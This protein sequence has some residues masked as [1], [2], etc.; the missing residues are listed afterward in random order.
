[1]ALLPLAPN[2]SPAQ[3]RWAACAIA[4][5]AL[6]AFHNALSGEFVLDDQASIV[7]NRTIRALWPFS[8]LLMPPAEAGVGGRPLANLTY[9]V[10][11]AISGQAVWSYRALNVMLHMAAALLLFG[12]VRRTVAFPVLRK[13]FGAHTLPIGALAAAVWAAHPLT[14]A[15]VDYV[16]QRT[17]QLMAL[18]YLAALYAFIRAANTG[19]RR[20]KVLCVAS[21]AAGMASKEV[22]VTA[23]VMIALYDRTFVA[24][25]FR[26]AWCARRRLYAALAGTWLLLAYLML[27]TTLADRGVGFGLGPA[28][29]EYALTQSHALLRYLRLALWP[30]PLVFDHGWAFVRN[31][32]GAVPYAAG[33]A[34]LIAGACALLRFRPLAGFAACWFLVILAPTTSIVPIIQQPIAE[35][36]VYL[37]LAGVVA[38]GVVAAWSAIGARTIAA[39]AVLVLAL[40][41]ATIDRNRDYRTA[42]IL[43]SDTIARAPG[44]AR[45]HNNLAAVRLRAGDASAAVHHASAALGLA[46]AYPDA[47]SN[48]ASALLQL[49][50]VEEAVAHFEVALRARPDLADTH[51][52]LGEALLHAGKV[53]RAISH[54]EAALRLDP[55]HARAHNNISVAWLQEGRVAQALAHAQAA[56]TLAPELYTARYNLGNA[57]LR[58]GRAGEAIGHFQAAL[59]LEPGFAPAAN[60]LGV[61][62]LASGNPRAAI[63]AFETAL[64]LNPAHPDARRNLEV[65]REAA[66][67]SGSR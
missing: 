43:W 13:R 23:P 1:M 65:A 33:A 46:P 54:L 59:R 24:G 51:Y 11:H 7:E 60:N 58:A 55:G 22:M 38:A 19:L 34:A 2:E 66:T 32:A 48:L 18:C 25:S 3:V 56:A 8:T 20:W 42:E 27:T 63:E 6:V 67:G 31:G 40:V 4:V 41:A 61:A 21:C 15:V 44:N 17:E 47:H 57:L 37:P 26:A 49:G 28:W 5:V 30:H 36:R 45:A 64:R 35:S 10:N 12:T 50:R 39:G 16:S 9:A 53:E 62:Q 14:T 52:N 29:Y